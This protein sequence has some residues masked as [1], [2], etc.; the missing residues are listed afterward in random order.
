M[1]CNKIQVKLGELI[2][3]KRGYDLPK[4]DRIDGNYPIISSSG[5][6]GK[7]NTF[8]VSGPGVV[9]G[10]SGQLGEVFYVNKD[11]WPLNT[12]LYVQDFKGNDP[13]YIYYFLKTINFKQLNAGSS[14]PTLNRN[15]AHLL[16]VEV[17]NVK[18]QKRIG[19][20]L[21]IF[22][23]KIE[24]NNQMLDTLEDM[25]STL[26]KRWFVDFEFPD[27]NGNPYKSS[28]GKMIDS[29]L[30]EIP[31]GWKIIPLS[32]VCSVKDGTHDS[33]KQVEIGYPLVTSKHLKKNK[34]DV[35][36][37]K[38]ISRQDYDKINVRSKVHQFDILISMIGTVG[39]TF[40]VTD[41]KIEFAIKNIGL[42]KTSEI[43]NL[44]TF[45]YLQ[46]TSER[47]ANFITLN[48]TGSTQQYISLT[49]LRKIPILMPRESIL[50]K[51]HDLVAST[52]NLSDSLK[53][54]IDTL[55]DTRDVLL[56]KLLTGELEV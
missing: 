23:K 18:E 44:S 45:I 25:A 4:N 26:F 22:D 54:E 32:E 48:T 17:V 8:K 28:G 20:V 40:Y 50:K 55:E 15:H 36:E 14:V 13:L 3:L 6:N 5:F 10:R 47:V 49:N 11:F 33:P 51:F 19:K 39:R 12:T 29:E 21:R 30:G 9:T 31:V 35:S 7:H 27:E 53:K 52:F 42:I 34:I 41:N 24:L 16:D 43:R 56:P 38:L 2:N 1:K 46:F 37:A